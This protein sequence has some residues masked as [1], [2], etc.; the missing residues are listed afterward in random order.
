MVWPNIHVHAFSKQTIRLIKTD[1]KR[2]FLHS[3]SI[4]FSAIVIFF[5]LVYQQHKFAN[6]IFATS[7]SQVLAFHH[8]QVEFALA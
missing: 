7:L 8:K 3:V 1:R 2:E 4:V 5:K 6:L